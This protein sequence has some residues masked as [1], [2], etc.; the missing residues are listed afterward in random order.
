M[1]N[2]N[3]MDILPLSDN[4]LNFNTCKF[5]SADKVE[6]LIKRCSCQG[7]DYT[8]SAYFCN[9]RQIFDVS[10]EICKECP[11]YESK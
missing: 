2:N 1:C 5:R 8:L 6:K 3:I 11:I 9:E 4:N 7:G 10:P